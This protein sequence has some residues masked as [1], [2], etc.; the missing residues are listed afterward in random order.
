M[1]DKSPVRAALPSLLLIV[2]WALPG[3]S[4]PPSAAAVDAALPVVASSAADR[5]ELSVVVYMGNLALVR[6][7]RQVELPRGRFLLHFGDVPEELAPSSVSLVPDCGLQLIEQQYRY[8][9]LTVDRLLRRYLGREVTL[10]RRD[11]RTGTLERVTGTLLS[12][13][14]GRVVRFGDSVAIDPEGRFILPA[15]PEDFV[16]RPT[17]AWLGESSGAGSCR[18]EASYLTTGIAWSCDY[19]L[20]LA[21]DERSAELSSWVSVNNRSGADLENATLDLVAGEVNRVTPPRPELMAAKGMRMAAEAAPALDEGFQQQP[22]FEYYRYRLGRVA[23]LPSMALKQL[24][25]FGPVRIEPRKLYRTEGGEQ[26]FYGPMAGEDDRQPVQV[27]LEWTNGGKQYP[28]RPLPAGVVRIYTADRD[29]VVFFSGE[30]RIGHTPEGETVTLRAGTAFDLVARRKQS[31]F[32]QLSERLRQVTVQVVLV[33]RK[34]EAVTVQVVERLP[35]DWKMLE[36]SLPFEQLNAQT[37]RFEP[38]VPP[39]GQ[40]VVSY[41]VQI[42]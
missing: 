25:L 24:E 17:L 40:T 38:R 18:L 11:E 21:A 10:E 28:G 31:D 20:R 42:L 8:E 30:D 19:V 16:L 39:Q 41:T 6:D 14:G 5:E 29:G 2:L 37:I 35:G 23:S 32:Q 15:V 13:E 7:R 4:R 26:L 1:R 22:A 36:H 3:H 27:L 12:L 34:D 33:N 9:V